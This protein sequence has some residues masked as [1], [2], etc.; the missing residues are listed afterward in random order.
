MSLLT[1]CQNASDE[2]EILEPTSVI[3]NPNS[4][5]QKLLR[6]AN[7]VGYR[8]MKVFNWQV[9]TK[10]TTYTSVATEEQTSFLAADFDRFCPETMWDRT[11]QYLISGPITGTEWQG[12]KAT[13]YSDTEHRKF[14]YRGGS[15]YIIPT[16]SA[17]KTIAYEYISKNWCQD[18]SLT[19]QS[20]WAADDD[21]GILDE[22]LITKGVVW[23]YLNAESLPNASQA[24]A[25]EEYFNILIENDRPNED[26]LVAGAIFGGSRGRGSRHFTGGPPVRGSGGLF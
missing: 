16:M 11:D 19:G 24:A 15:V 7:K 12:L 26:I 18:S 17:G 10:E 23:E 8:L 21:T 2:L 25:Y 22:E 3:G 20:V 14:R 6:L 1:I 13:T 5:V 4:E 9:L